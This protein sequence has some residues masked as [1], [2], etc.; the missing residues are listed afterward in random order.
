MIRLNGMIVALSLVL[1]ALLGISGVAQIPLVEFERALLEIPVANPDR[2]LRAIEIGFGQADFP[3]EELLQLIER[4]ATHTAPSPEK[5]ALLLPI[6]SALEEG[7]PIEGLVNK[8]FEGLARRIPLPDIE[9]G[10]HQRLILLGEVRDLLYSK[11][12]FSVAPGAPQSAPSA[13]PTPRFNHLLIH[14][15]DAIGDHLEG[16]GSP[17]DGHVLYQGVRE[18]LIMLEGVTL[19]PEDVELV[20]ERIGPSDLTDAALAAV[21]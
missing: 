8:A 17:F 16:G 18:R 13:I 19:P 14:I 12:V 21:T 9:H 5:E 7:L 11:G 15:A 1:V 10:L 4:L 20:L 3:A 6:V 2:F